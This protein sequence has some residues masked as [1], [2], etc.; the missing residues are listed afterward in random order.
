MT[1]LKSHTLALAILL[2]LTFL[3]TDGAT[4]TDTIS[5]GIKNEL[6]KNQED[7]KET[8]DYKR[9]MSFLPM[10][11]RRKDEEKRASSFFGLRGKKDFPNEDK[12]AMSF[13]GLRGKK[14]FANED[15]KAMSFFG[16]RGKKDFANED[17]R[18]MS[19]FGLRGKKDFANEDKRAMSFFGLRGKRNYDDKRASSFFGLRGKKDGIDDKQENSFFGLKGKPNNL[20]EKRGM[21][22]FG[23]RGKKDDYLNQAK[24]FMDFSLSDY[25]EYHN[26]QENQGDV[27]NYVS[28]LKEDYLRNQD[29]SSGSYLTNTLEDQKKRAGAFFGMRGKR[30]AEK[31]RNIETKEVRIVP[32]I[33][34]EEFFASRG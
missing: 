7:Q 21:S 29:F 16:L 30:N 9:S 2:Y 20:E 17:K 22:F 33:K 32:G 18:A 1:L 15:K 34:R 5:D 27:D 4:H 10:R 14:N 25:D 26:G 11:G 31:D 24:H 28:N 8:Q 12:R 6:F 13:F 3:A 19:F 23:L